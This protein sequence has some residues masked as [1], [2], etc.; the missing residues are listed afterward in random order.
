MATINGTSGNDTLM[1]SDSDDFIFGGDGNDTIDGGDG[2]DV[3]DPGSGVDTVLGGAGND[4]FIVTSVMTG[5]PAPTPTTFNGGSGFDTFDFSSFSLG[6]QAFWSFD[7][8]TN[9]ISVANYRFSQVERIIGTSG[10]DL[11]SLFNINFS[12]EIRGNAGNDNIVGG[13]RADRLFGGTGD[14]VITGAAGDSIFGEQGN[15]RL[16]VEDLLTVLAD[17]GDGVDTL[18]LGG[19]SRTIFLDGRN[20]AGSTQ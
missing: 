15:D 9:N 12:I 10:I 13:S 11:F 14:D 16:T 4:T 19:S 17:G 6:P 3:I 5:F 8:S 7:A 18:R 2:N 20:V 1:G